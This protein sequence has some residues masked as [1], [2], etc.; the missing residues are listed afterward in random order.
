MEGIIYKIILIISKSNSSFDS[1]K[2]RDTGSVVIGTIV[3]TRRRRRRR[4]SRRMSP[5]QGWYSAAAVV[6]TDLHVVPFRRSPPRHH[7]SASREHCPAIDPEPRTVTIS[8]QLHTCC[9]TTDPWLAA[10]PSH[11]SRIETNNFLR[12]SFFREEGGDIL[13]TA[14]VQFSIHVILFNSAKLP[15]RKY[16][17]FSLQ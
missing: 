7:W 2:T 13:R 15:L 11:D 16:S 1:L 4:I 10:I 17:L 6:G 8:C 5:A 9:C 3:K 14:F 12:I